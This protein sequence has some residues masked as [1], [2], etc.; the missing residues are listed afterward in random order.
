MELAVSAI[1]PTYNRA[2]L[3]E[4][5][6]RSALA[7]AVPDDEILVIDDG[8]T[9]GTEQVV[10]PYRYRVRYIR[11]EN[12]GAGAARNRGVAEA[13]KPLVAFLDSDDEWLP[14]RLDLARQV[15]QRRPDVLFCFSDFLSDHAG[16]IVRRALRS[17]HRQTRS[18][19]ERG[20]PG[21]PYSSIAPLPWGWE[22]FNCHIGSI[23]TEQIAAC[24]I[25]TI[26]VTARREEAAAALEFAE[27]LPT[28]EDWWCFSHLARRGPGA[29]LDCETAI[30]HCHRSPRLTDADTLI[31]ADTRLRMLERIWGAD[32]AFLE[33]HGDL[34]RQVLAEQRLRRAKGLILHGRVRDAREELASLPQAPALYRALAALPGPLVGGLFELR[35]R[36]HGAR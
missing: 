29:Y 8:S 15:L 19:D 4:R 24:L 33:A 27:D 31:C 11:T 1:I 16:K 6:I 7:A 36:L 30:Q 17:W 18:W 12:R 26:T 5:A 28:Y 21:A 34:Y 32:P 13:R 23:Y 22:D 25:C 10:S 3:V 9:D 20:A 14:W 35:R 2:R